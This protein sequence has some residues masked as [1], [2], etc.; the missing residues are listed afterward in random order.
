MIGEISNGVINIGGVDP[1]ISQEKLGRFNYQE[2][3]YSK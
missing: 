3:L 2:R 1:S